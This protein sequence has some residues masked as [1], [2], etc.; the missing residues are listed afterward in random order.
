MTN[1]VVLK[2][3]VAPVQVVS[4]ARP[5]RIQTNGA[6][7]RGLGGVDG[8]SAGF[9]FVYDD[10]STA[11]ADPGPGK[12]RLN[13]ATPASAT[14]MALA[15]DLS[16]G[17]DVSALVV[18]ALRNSG[19]IIVEYG[20]NRIEYD[21]LPVVD[22]TAWLQIALSNATQVGTLSGGDAT[23]LFFQSAR[24]RNRAGEHFVNVKEKYGCDGTSGDRAKIQSAFDNEARGQVLVFPTMIYGTDHTQLVLGKSMNLLGE[25]DEARI[26]T[27]KGSAHT[28]AVLKVQIPPG[29]GDFGGNEIRHMWMRHLSL[30]NFDHATEGA[31]GDGALLVCTDDGA[32]PIRDLELDGVRLTGDNDGSIAAITCGYDGDNDQD[33]AQFIMRHSTVTGGLIG[34]NVVDGCRLNGNT[35]IGERMA[36]DL[37]AR[38]SAAHVIQENQFT[39]RDGAG[40]I[41]SM[42]MLHFLR[43]TIEHF[44]AN[45]NGDL[46]GGT[47]GVV[48]DSADLIIGDTVPGANSDYD[49]SCADL[50]ILQNN[51]NGTSSHVGWHIYMKGYVND[52]EVDKNS[53]AQAATGDVYLGANVKR[54]SIPKRNARRGRHG[55]SFRTT[56]AAGGGNDY[57]QTFYTARTPVI[58]DNG[59][60]NGG[61]GDASAKRSSDLAVGVSPGQTVFTLALAA[62][63]SYRLQGFAVVNSISQTA[64][65]AL[66]YSGTTAGGHVI[67]RGKSEVSLNRPTDFGQTRTPLATGQ[68]D[69]LEIEGMIETS[70]AGNL[71]LQIYYSSGGNGTVLD[72]AYLTAEEI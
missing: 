35:W 23:S 43:N 58:S 68:E 54:V 37:S 34:I 38:R 19:R 17:T 70:T 49:Y 36:L 44:A 16:G 39:C 9:R 56:G 60:D 26:Y 14:A 52:G 72:G 69:V 46:T 57:Q 51:F 67:L 71:T 11:M 1:H 24:G 29:E 27:Q 22:N 42:Q 5:A 10:S 21:A 55:N 13:H 63:R 65:L 45:Q 12:F 7:L 30:V 64:V 40:F 6:G 41:R 28:G 15:A 66:N 48:A 61:W 47:A 3:G 18:D 59:T 8:A 20:D 50:E 33:I 2:A 32:I 25:S 62:G 53:F 4:A 31:N